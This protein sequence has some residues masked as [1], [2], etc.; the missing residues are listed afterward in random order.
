VAPVAAALADRRSPVIMLAGGYLVQAAAMA[1]TAAAII[2]GAPL[3]AY[4]AGAEP[5]SRDIP[6]P[7]AAEPG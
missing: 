7:G 6:E 1:A 5:G 4:A 2:A 3:A